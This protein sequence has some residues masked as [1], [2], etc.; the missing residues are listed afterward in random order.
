MGLELKDDFVNQL[1]LKA[2]RKLN[3]ELP[4]YWL[5]DS[6]D[7]YGDGHIDGQTELARAILKSLGVIY[8]IGAGE[9]K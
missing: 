2:Q 3:V 8:A 5:D 1:I 9:P 6:S 4:N 7:E